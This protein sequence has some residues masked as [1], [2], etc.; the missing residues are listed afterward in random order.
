MDGR[1]TRHESDT[2]SKPVEYPMSIF[3]ESFEA[4]C[5]LGDPQQEGN[6]TLVPILGG[7]AGGMV[8]YMM[9]AEALQSEG[10]LVTE[11]E[12]AATVPKLLVRNRLDHPVLLLDGEELVGAM[13]NRVANTTMLLAANSETVIPVSC[14]E[15]GRWHQASDQFSDSGTVMPPSARSRKMASVGDSLSQDGS[16]ASD[17]GEVWEAIDGLSAAT[18]V[19]GTT[20]A[21]RDVF[22]GHEAQLTDYARAFGACEGQV[23]LVGLVNGEVVGLDCLS[24]PAAYHAASERLTRSYAMEALSSPSADMTTDTPASWAEAFLGEI[25]DA[26]EESYPGVG[27]GTEFRYASPG[28]T[29]VALVHDGEVLHASFQRSTLPVPFPRSYWVRPGLLL[30]GYY[31]GAPSKAEASEKLM[32]LLDAGIRCF[33]NLVEEDEQGAGGTPLHPYSRLLSNLAAERGV[34]VTYLRIPVR[35]VDI[36]TPDSMRSILDAI[37]SALGRRLPIYVHCWGGRGRT[38]TVVGCHLIRRGLARGEAALAAIGR[39]RRNEETADKPSPETE[40][41]RDMVR[42]W[43]GDGRFP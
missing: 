23:G 11:V 37:D 5:R 39:L 17:Q 2:A 33:I 25:E 16:R 22:A 3:L 4:T 24:S 35:D 7:L 15:Q 20:G 32:S 9:L 30:A 43:A 6:L 29:G 12:E 34:E 36:P 21:M 28:L 42:A 18:E 8:S 27:L 38:G 10:F 31:P 19:R 40:A 13:Q 26:Q 14:S 41:Q 1:T